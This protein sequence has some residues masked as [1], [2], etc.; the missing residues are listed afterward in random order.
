MS[1]LLLVLSSP[2]GGGKTTI[3]RVLLRQRGDVGYS[4]SATTRPVRKGERNAV[5]YH[6]VSETD[7]LRQVDAGLFLEWARYGG[8][9]YGT[10]ESEVSRV[11]SQ[12][13][14]VVLDIDVQ[15][16][17]QIRERRS[18]SVSI[19]ILPPT[20][21]VLVRR[22]RARERED[23]TQMHERLLRAIEELDEAPSYDYVVVN[24]DL[25]QAVAEVS[26]VLDAETLRVARRADLTRTL[27][28]LREGLQRAAQHVAPS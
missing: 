10:L 4:V 5:D 1:Q 14:H 26:A 27:D 12:G 8:H 24:D 6:F 28:E 16:A 21:P 11:L 19:F 20:A 22:L 18:D 13:K 3:A 9:L 15:G 23:A 17:R 7:F 2:S 25:D